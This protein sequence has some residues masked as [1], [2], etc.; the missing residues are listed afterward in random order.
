MDANLNSISPMLSDVKTRPDNILAKNDVKK[1]D[2]SSFGKVLE[3]KETVKEPAKKVSKEDVRAPLKRKDVQTAEPIQAQASAKAPVRIDKAAPAT[4][5]NVEAAGIDDKAGVVGESFDHMAVSYPVS[6]IAKDSLDEKTV[7]SLKEQGLWDIQTMAM[8]QPSQ[9]LSL[10][11]E[12]ADAFGTEDAIELPVTKPIAQ[13]MASL[14]SELGVKPDRL[15]QAFKKL[16]PDQMQMSPKETMSQIVKNLNLEPKDQPR[17]TELFTKMLSQME[18]VRDQVLNPA[19]LAGLAGVSTQVAPKLDNV[20]D[21]G[22]GKTPV[23]GRTQAAAVYAQNS[24]A[25]K[26]LNAESLS[27]SEKVE[28]PA[29][30]FREAKAL[31]SESGE[32]NSKVSTQGAAQSS[33]P[34]TPNQFQVVPQ[35]QAQDDASAAALIQ[36]GHTATPDAFTSNNIAA[37][38]NAVNDKDVKDLGKQFKDT[39]MS[40]KNVEVSTPNTGASQVAANDFAPAKTEMPGQSSSV[41]GGVAAGELKAGNTDKQEAIRSIVNQAQMLAQ[42]GGG[43]IRMSLKPDHLGEI[44]LKVA[45]EGSRVNVQ[46]TTERGEVKKLI[47][48]SVNEL[49]H[50][51]AGHNLSMDKLDVSVGNRETQNF[52][53]GQP[54]FGAAREFANNFHQQQN[55]RRDFT[56]SLSSLRGG[57]QKAMTTMDHAAQAQR[58]M[59]ARSSASGRLNVVA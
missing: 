28:S 58:T 23:K 1:E 37:H 15:I 32:M 20:N 10:M 22:V 26:S 53:K 36:Q 18:A 45:M 44:Q 12:A 35:A 2:G 31:K 17:A 46:M 3:E 30:N 48:Q 11:K 25:E 24:G 51:L 8:A 34:Q 49:R 57:P 14:E 50:G 9:Q 27:K 38:T 4:E 41:G 52:T 19:M 5:V 55:N 54:D 16:S 47:E 13:F 39:K 33:A 21:K 42:K 40:V 6:K 43:E 7:T 56:E 59:S 29:M